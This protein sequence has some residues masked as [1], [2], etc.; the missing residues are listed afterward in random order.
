MTD[1]KAPNHPGQFVA[2]VASNCKVCDEHY[3]LLL[4]LPQFPASRPGQFIQIA[5]RDLSGER[6]ADRELDWLP[7][8]PP[9]L[10]GV[11][12]AG[13][14]AM[15]RRPFSLAGR[16]DLVPPV[17]SPAESRGQ[18]TASANAR[19]TSAAGALTGRLP[20][21]TSSNEKTSASEGTGRTHSTPTGE[22]ELEIIQRVVGVGTNWL[23]KLAPGDTVQ[24]IGPV[25][26]GFE[27]PPPGGLAVMVGGGVGIP[28]ML[29]L[30]TWLSGVKAVA[31]CGATTRRL[32]ALNI[33]P[34]LPDNPA[35]PSL[36]IDEFARCGVPA[37]ISTDDGS[38]GFRG[39]V[40]QALERYLDNLPPDLRAL[41]VVYTC[42]P[43]PMMKR[44]AEIAATRDIQCQVAVERA[45]ACGMGTC[46]SCVIK[47]KK[48]DPARPPLAGRDWCY[49]LACTDGPVFKGT[50]LLW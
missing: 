50:D 28:P 38:C 40:T 43:E 27:P 29:Y 30:G 10:T 49:R 46:Q 24:V 47:V 18:T 9:R 3:R 1:S 44:V 39:L 19:G 37:V 4:R 41:T 5:C 35:I 48:H 7:D 34:E 26:I 11:E 33:R 8:E 12:L 25:G 2:R 13:P 6:F 22:V 16:R 21:E 31:F 23:S 32:L 15:L 14:L 42:G 17:S 45:M 20:G 36:C